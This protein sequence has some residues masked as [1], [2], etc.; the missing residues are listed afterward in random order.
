MK[1]LH[2]EFS[3]LSLLL[4][5]TLYSLNQVLDWF[6]DYRA[7]QGGLTDVKAL[8]DIGLENLP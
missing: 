4:W 8:P 7:E 6:C 5:F 1:V 3:L 2:H